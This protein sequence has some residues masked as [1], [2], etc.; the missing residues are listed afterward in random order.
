MRESRIPDGAGQYHPTHHRRCP[1]NGFIPVPA[2][3]G[4]NLLK[5]LLQR[6]FDFGRR[7]SNLLGERGH[8]AAVAWIIPV[9]AAQ[10]LVSIRSFAVATLAALH[11]PE[12]NFLAVG[13][14]SGLELLLRSK[15]GIEGAVRQAG[16]LHHFAH[17]Y[18]LKSPFTEQAGSL[19]DNPFMF[20]GGLFDGIAHIFL[21][22]SI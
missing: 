5:P 10:V 19:V 3:R 22:P 9:P 1:K 21:Y 8:G 17:A 12:R 6:G 13:N 7:A 18:V 11:A 2:S 16:G 4:K 15:V 20:C 14:G